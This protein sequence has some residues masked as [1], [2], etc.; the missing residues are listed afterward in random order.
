MFAA[1]LPFF[2]TVLIAVF[3]T[4]LLISLIDLLSLKT[5]MF[6]IGNWQAPPDFIQGQRQDL[7]FELSLSP[8]R[9][10]EEIE[11]DLPPERRQGPLNCSYEKERIHIHFIPST[12][13]LFR[14]EEIFLRWHSFLGFWKL[15]AR[16]R[17][18]VSYRVLPSLPAKQQCLLIAQQYEKS[19]HRRKMKRQDA[20][21]EFESL[22]NYVPGDDT[23]HIDWM[24]S[25]RRAQTMLRSFRAESDQR[26]IIALDCSRLM[27]GLSGSSPKFDEAWKLLYS[28]AQIA[29]SQKD[30]IA[31]I[32]FSNH[33]HHFTPY[34][35]GPPLLS[36]IR[37]QM[38]SSRISNLDPDY[39]ALYECLR[40]HY[41]K[42]SLVVV[43]GDFV[44]KLSGFEVV[45]TLGL[46]TRTY[47]FLFVGIRDPEIRKLATRLPEDLAKAYENDTAITLL[48]DRREVLLRMQHMGIS[49]LD[50]EA[51]ELTAPLLSRYLELTERRG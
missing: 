41:R 36:H 18:S 6:E 19:E 40:A 2:N 29:V 44:D 10:P 12:R 34:L 27:S 31:L 13:G 37:Q 38:A 24:A 25:A 5:P 26:L 47:R 50:G 48:E 21:M 39:N 22:R 43:L 3:C 14:L 28:L 16:I 49:T 8:S 51:E 20:H 4:L 15:T 30:Q 1:L 11:C 33:V 32:L 35:K 46:N 23:R 45:K 9:S 7:F 17:A 42:R